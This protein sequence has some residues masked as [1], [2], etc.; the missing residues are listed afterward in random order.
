MSFVA[1]FHRRIVETFQHE[2]LTPAKAILSGTISVQELVDTREAKLD[3]S[4]GV[5]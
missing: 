5:N 1:R 2:A 4:L 3:E